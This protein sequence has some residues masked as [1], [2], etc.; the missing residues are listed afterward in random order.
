LYEPDGCCC[1]NAAWQVA[2]ALSK[3]CLFWGKHL[4][5]IQYQALAVYHPYA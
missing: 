4:P 1:C 3:F 5:C 2:G